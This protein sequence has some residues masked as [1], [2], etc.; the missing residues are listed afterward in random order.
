VNQVRIY[1]PQLDRHVTVPESAV[2]IH[3]ASGWIPADEAPT[4][5]KPAEIPPAKPA[6]T[7]KPKA[8]AVAAKDKE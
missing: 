7:S 8:P 4:A 5:D 3:R 1:H 2:Q 6:A